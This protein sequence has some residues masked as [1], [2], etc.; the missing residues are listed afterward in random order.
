MMWFAMWSR[1]WNK[2]AG[3]VRRGA[4]WFY[5][6]VYQHFHKLLYV[7]IYVYVEKNVPFLLRSYSRTCRVLHPNVLFLQC[8]QIR[9]I[10]LDRFNRS[11][12]FK[13]VRTTTD[14][15]KL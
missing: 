3:C 14:E 5:M 13:I 1:S 2:R 10:H 8:W 12:G 4:L 9:A 11:D 6:F 15:L 7:Y